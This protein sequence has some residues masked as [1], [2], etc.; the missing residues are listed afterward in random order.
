MNWFLVYV[1]SQKRDLFLKHLDFIIN[2]N[3]INELFSDRFIPT[4]SM[5]KDVV[6]LQIT[7]LKLARTYLRQVE[8]FSRIEPKALSVNQV[9]QFLSK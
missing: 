2:K 4:D 5:Y 6:L 8:Y 3:N 7:D 9:N 1:R